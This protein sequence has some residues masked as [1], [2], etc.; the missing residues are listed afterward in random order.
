MAAEQRR[1]LRWAALTV[2][3]APVLLA[4]ASCG[5]A[6]T[7]SSPPSISP[8]QSQRASSSSSPLGKMT[9]TSVIAKLKAAGMP[10]GK[11]IV[12]TAATDV[13]HLLGRPN[14]YLSKA[15]FIDTRIKS[16]EVAGYSLGDIERGGGVEVFSDPAG[17]KARMDYIQALAKG[18]PMFAEYDYTLGPAL[19]RLSTILTP[20][21]ARA[22]EHALARL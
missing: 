5:G 12:Y 13:N 17:A 4:A 7:S 3:I 11:V 6:G 1:C 14:G 2:I 8:T 9:A 21:Q 20:T 22:Y 19:L 18:S 16:S 10:I 15:A